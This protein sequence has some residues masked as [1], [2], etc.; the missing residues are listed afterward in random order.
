MS[1]RKTL[2]EFFQS[3][4]SVQ[5]EISFPHEDSN[6]NG[7]IEQGDDIGVDP[8]SGEK[9]LDVED[10]TTGLIGDY[11][12]FLMSSYDHKTGTFNSKISNFYRPGPKNTRSPSNDRGNLVHNPSGPDGSAKVFAGSDTQLGATLG[13]YSNSGYIS[14][15]DSIVKKEGD[16]QNHEILAIEKEKIKNKGSTF[17]NQETSEVVIGEPLNTLK[18]NNRYYPAKFNQQGVAYAEK[19]ETDSLTIDD[20]DLHIYDTLGE[21]EENDMKIKISNL[22]SLVPDLLKTYTGINPNDLAGKTEEEVFEIITNSEYK[23]T[24]SKDLKASLQDSVPDSIKNSGYHQSKGDTLRD[25]RSIEVQKADFSD[26]SYENPDYLISLGAVR[27]KIITTLILDYFQTN[28][29]KNKQRSKLILQNRGRSPVPFFADTFYPILDCIDEGLSVLFSNNISISDF[30]AKLG[31]EFSS[32]K[33][34]KLYWIPFFKAI[35]HESENIV[36][37]IENETTKEFLSSMKSSK[38]ASFVNILA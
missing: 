15:L 33:D 12:N 9:L 34:S 6:A 26:Y 11:V 2:K 18:G 4:G 25:E 13:R 22:F 10:S 30:N 20:T 37:K 23:K 36:N 31:T 38:I 17:N 21:N 16:F 5:S 19:G 27:L 8:E 35:I 32:I 1:T 28:S 14:N 29:V 24:S 7:K 3:K